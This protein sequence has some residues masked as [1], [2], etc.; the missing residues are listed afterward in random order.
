MFGLFE[1]FS[2]MDGARLA[3]WVLRFS[4]GRRPRPR[5][6][7]LLAGRTTAAAWRLAGGVPGGACCAPSC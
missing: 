2:E 4:G 1:A 6:A 3:D 5:A 7:V